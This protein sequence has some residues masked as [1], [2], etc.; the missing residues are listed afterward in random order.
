MLGIDSQFSG[1]L[2]IIHVVLVLVALF[3]IIKSNRSTGSKI[4][5]F[6]IVFF[7]PLVGLI[8]YWAIARD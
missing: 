8:L 6:L 1:L 7:F 2:G 4:G 3:D 5:W